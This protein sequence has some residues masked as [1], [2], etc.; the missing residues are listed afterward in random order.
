MA[1]VCFSVVLA[2][3]APFTA[4]RAADASGAAAG[5]N[6]N[7]EKIHITSDTMELDQKNNRVEFAGNVVATRLD[8]TLHA[9]HIQVVLYSDVEKEQR[10]A[11]GSTTGDNDN[12]KQMV[13][14]GSVEIVQET[15]T[16]TADKAVYSTAEQTIVLTGAAPR[17]VSG[18]SFIT[19][20]RITL[21]QADNRVVVESDETKRVSAFFD[22]SDSAAVKKK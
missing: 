15:S 11:A 21:Y 7:E 18:K 19:G 4:A 17:V 16:A 9:D 10:A 22:S 6:N 2:A 12:I 13:A 8:V 20:T 14:T 5:G 1:A 3:T